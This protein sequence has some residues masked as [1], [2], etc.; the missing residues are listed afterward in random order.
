MNIFITGGLGFVGRNLS[1]A[2]LLK[3]HQVIAIGRSQNPVMID[4][5]DF[6]YVAAD[7]TQAGEWQDLL[8]D[9]QVVVN[10]AGKSIFTLWTERTKRQIYDSRILTTRNLVEALPAGADTTLCSTSAI[11]YYG[12]RGEDILTEDEPAGDDF[13]AEVGRD[14][15]KEALQAE[16]K[17]A[18]VV[19]TRYGIV[20]D[21]D[22]GA[23]AKMVPAFRMF[24]GGPLGSGRQW[25]SWIHMRDL[26]KAYLFVVDR[27]DV[28]GPLNY[29]APEPVRNEQ[30]AKTLAEKLT[31]PAFMPAP[32]FMIKLVLG[33][34]GKVL[35]ASQRVRPAALERAGFEFDYPDL[36][37]ALAQ[38]VDQ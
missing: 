28:R 16:S 17:G 9:Q 30:L 1:N 10:L 19:L 35:L 31:R 20:L 38:I 14:W 7:T 26:L 21:R 12:D 4:H 13:L 29:C 23:M 11:G 22:G 32:A 25:F 6:R 3:G 33:E 27:Q 37:S 36:D 24:V 18:R 2:F 8:R 5:P 34:F 15:E